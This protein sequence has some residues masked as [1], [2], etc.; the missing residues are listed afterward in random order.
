M[1]QTIDSDK[2]TFCAGISHSRRNNDYYGSA[3]NNETWVLC[4]EKHKVNMLSFVTKC[5]ILPLTQQRK[6]CLQCYVM[7]CII[8]HPTDDERIT[9]ISVFVFL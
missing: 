2:L 7:C 6:T 4:Y 5:A 8:E 3:K 9:T 1:G